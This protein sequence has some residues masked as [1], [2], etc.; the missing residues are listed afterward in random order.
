M[1]FI[2]ALVLATL[3]LWISSCFETASTEVPNELQVALGG[4]TY[5]DAPLAQR[6]IEIVDEQQKVI[7]VDTT[8][9]LG[10]FSL[11]NQILDVGSVYTIQTSDSA[12]QSYWVAG[13]DSNFIRLNPVSTA[14]VALLQPSSKLIKQRDSVAMAWFGPGFV[15]S[16]INGKSKKL[17]SSELVQKAF[18]STIS[19]FAI[20]KGIGSALSQMA[21]VSGSVID[22][23][24]FQAR[25]SKNLQK[26]KLNNQ[27]GA[28]LLWETSQRDN[29]QIWLERINSAKE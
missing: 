23:P 27:V 6:R 12:L 5:L 15:H 13:A 7:A 19:S 28:E 21:K 25:L 17:D 8:D 16:K 11:P 9:S 29:V 26:A 4:D 24:V 20:G 22:S 3:P 18:W 2:F 10:A 1:K 14:L